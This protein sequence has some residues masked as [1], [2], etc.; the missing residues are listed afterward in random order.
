MQRNPPPSRRNEPPQDPRRGALR[1]KMLA[2]R[3]ELRD[4][5]VRTKLIGDRVLKWLRNMPVTRVAF[6]WAIRGEPDIS[7][8]MLTWAAESAQRMLALPVIA[9]EQ[10]EFAPWRS[11]SSMRSGTYGIR[12]PDTPERI[13]PQLIIVP[14][15]AI[16]RQC[17]RIG[18]GAGYYDRTLGHMAVRPT[19]VGV[20]F[21]C[22][23]VQSVDPEPHDVRLDLGISENGNV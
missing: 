6:Y 11:Q 18:Y 17:Y 14:C 1:A 2:A 23:V 3:M 16:D 20:A 12:E 9:G 21:A 5:E 13:K 19:T 4:R 8:Q 7:A 10:L 15:V 22:N